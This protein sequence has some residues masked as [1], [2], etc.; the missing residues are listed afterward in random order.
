MVVYI[1]LLVLRWVL[2]APAMVVYINLLV[3]RWALQ[4]P[5]MVVYINLIVLR[6]A[7]QGPAAAC[8]LAAPRQP[9]GSPDL[10]IPEQV[11]SSIISVR[12]RGTE[13]PES[14]KAPPIT[15]TST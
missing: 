14:A 12:S 9:D 3:L 2:Q 7:L 15:L 13:C 6:W 8:F 4:A 11:R 1:N 5:A 10:G